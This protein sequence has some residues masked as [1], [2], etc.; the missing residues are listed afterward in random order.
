MNKSSRLPTKLVGASPSRSRTLAPLLR[1]WGLPV[2][3]IC[4]RVRAHGTW[5]DP[6]DAIRELRTY[7][8]VVPPRLRAA[9]CPECE[10]QIAHRRAA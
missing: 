10:T 5:L 6:G 7:E 4:L 2:C 8:S 1:R 9:V 3:S